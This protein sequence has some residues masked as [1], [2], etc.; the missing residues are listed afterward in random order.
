M[1]YKSE[2]ERAIDDVE[3]AIS[4]LRDKIKTLVIVA[5]VIGALFGFIAGSIR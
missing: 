3:A 2:A 5:F 4:H 1:T